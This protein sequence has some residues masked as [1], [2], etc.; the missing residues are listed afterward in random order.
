MIELLL[1]A[2]LECVVNVG[3]RND[4]HVFVVSRVHHETLRT[5]RIE[6]V[7]TVDHVKEVHEWSSVRPDLVVQIVSEIIEVKF[8]FLKTDRKSLSK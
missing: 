2:F 1:E 8:N 3:V 7:Q 4:E 6:L 5:R